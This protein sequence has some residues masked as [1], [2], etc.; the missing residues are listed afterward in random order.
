MWGALAQSVV[1]SASSESAGWAAQNCVGVLFTMLFTTVW[2]MHFTLSC[3]SSV[4]FAA[5]STVLSLDRTVGGRLFSASLFIGCM[6]S[7]GLIGG[8]ISSLAWL[9]RGDSQGV[10]IYAEDAL[11]QV[12]RAGNLTLS[13]AERLGL[14]SAVNPILLGLQ[15]TLGELRNEQFIQVVGNVLELAESGVAE[16]FAS[17]APPIVTRLGPVVYETVGA[18][19]P[20]INAGFWALLIVLF[21]VVCL[22][23]AVARAH[24]NFKIGLVMAISTLFCGSQVIFA[25]LMPITG[26]RLYWTQFVLGYVKVA[27]VNGAAMV[28]AA[29]LVY[30]K[31]SHDT[32]RERFG[33][34]FQTCGVILSRI[35]G[36]INRIDVGARESKADGVTNDAE[37]RSLRDEAIAMANA[38]AS[39]VGAHATKQKEKKGEE[40]PQPDVIQPP[41]A[42]TAFELRASCQTIEDALLTCLLEVPLPGMT[43]HV[44]ARRSDFVRLL[45]C[46]RTVLSTVCC[47]ETIFATATVEL[48][49]CGHDTAPVQCALAAVAAVVSRASSVL[50]TMPVMGPCKGEGLSWRPLSGQ[51][52][53]ELEES[54]AAFDARV[55]DAAIKENI[56]VSQRGR[57]MMLL[58]MNVQTLVRDA[59]KCEAL[60]ATALDVPVEA[61]DA[62][63]SRG[64]DE[65]ETEDEKGE[66][67]RGWMS[68]ERIIENGYLPG[69]LVHSVLLSGLAQYALI[70]MSA[71]TFFKG[72]IA[73]ARSRAERVRICKDVYVQFAV[74]FWFACTVTV[75]SIVLILWK[76]KFSS[77]NQLQNTYDITYF[78]FVWQPIYFWLTVAICLQFQV[79]AAVMRA[80]L[81]TT[82]TALGG[83]LGYCAM[84]NGNLAQNP[85]WICGIVCT[86]N[87]FFSLF[88][89]VK[90]LRYSVF[91]ANFTFNAVVVCQYYGCSCDLAGE[92]NIYGGKV[93]STMLGSIF[94]ILVS[95]A[96]L[97]VYTSQKVLDL[98]YDVMTDGL[99]L[100]SST[101]RRDKDLVGV[102]GAPKEDLLKLDVDSVDK[103]IDERL[104]AVHKEIEYNS[105]S[106]DQLLLLTWTILPTPPVV[107]LLKNRLERLGV[108]LREFAQINAQDR[109]AD[110]GPASGPEFSQ[111]MSNIYTLLEDCETAAHALMV[112]VRANFDASGSKELQRTRAALI[113]DLADLE[114]R[115]DATTQIFKKWDSERKVALRESELITIARSRLAVLAFKEYYVICILLGVT[116]ATIDRDAWYSA[117]SSW[118]G[119]RPIV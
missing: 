105:V 76:A 12:A 72:C 32:A 54:V 30:V 106:K 95:W 85:Y 51:F 24:V 34:T 31:S 114:A 112:N 10:A 110:Q 111:F 20:V 36:N 71:I 18:S 27:L 60:V 8:G 53:A 37:C 5:A 89:V 52:W 78:F 11:A 75:M 35:A 13:E 57:D 94:S 107:H 87:G 79:E 9:A 104:V 100:V 77:D 16:E 86:V 101:W 83:T 44:G 38:T 50:A 21:A 96:I 99:T 22:P 102:G 58:L 46:L 59:R 81:R 19:I 116:E 17:L 115:L 92:T 4:L 80:V 26:I 98:E 70:V 74:K 69:L 14:I 82:M 56:R 103:L 29:C 48:A 113:V 65:K 93:L 47:I 43:S 23:L 90:P 88:C 7:G 40:A 55:R 73:F 62:R 49:L 1:R 97:P 117:W 6:L 41:E 28:C 91:L 118:F 45:G 25:C 39:A 2:R 68:K 61:D 84:L 64:A 109:G 119:R 63:A 15:D 108:F 33:E 42:P 67:A 66:T 3:V